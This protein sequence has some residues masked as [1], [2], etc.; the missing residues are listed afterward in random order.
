MLRTQCAL[1]HNNGTRPYQSFN[2]I[3]T[4]ACQ[5][6]YVIRTLLR[7]LFTANIIQKVSIR[8]RFPQNVNQNT[9]SGERQSEHVFQRTSSRK[10][11]PENVKQNTFSRERQSEH[12]F[13]R[14]SIRIRF[15]ENVNQTTFLRE[16]QFE[17]A[18][19]G[20]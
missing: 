13:Q 18:L 16:R 11:F 12:V 10:R 2:Q 4:R 1:Y 7:T 5:L 17:N 6:D 8:T 19:Q 20:A 14:T 3:I 9:F 15:P